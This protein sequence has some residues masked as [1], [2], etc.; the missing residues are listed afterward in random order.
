MRRGP[1]GL[2]ATSVAAA[3]AIVARE[4][5]ASRRVRIFRAMPLVAAAGIR[6]DRAMRKTVLALAGLL[7]VSG[8]EKKEVGSGNRVAEVAEVGVVLAIADELMPPGTVKEEDHSLEIKD[9]KVMIS[10]AGQDVEG[11]MSMKQ[12]K[13]RRF[14]SLSEGRYRV[15]ILEEMKTERTAMMGQEQPVKE[16]V[17]PIKGRSVIVERGADGV[18]TAKL[19]SGEPTAEMETEIARIAGNLTAGKDVQVYGTVARKIG[20]EWTVDGG[21]L[22]E[23]E[24]A[25]GTIKLRFAGIEEHKGERCAKLTGSLDLT[26]TPPNSDTPGLKMR[27]AGDLV[28]FR[29]LEHRT[30]LTNELHGTMEMFGEMEPQPG[31]KMTMKVEGTM[32]ALGAGKVTK[33]D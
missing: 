29:S 19:E 23:L 9:A 14:E 27:M 8:C 24:N 4:K 2:L 11:T 31:M 22:M 20:D 3:T 13:N 33:V 15:T 18:W 10:V 16:T 12:V 7:L 30:D 17:S 32:E 21:D 25:E 26:G 6:L 1:G 28:I 5:S